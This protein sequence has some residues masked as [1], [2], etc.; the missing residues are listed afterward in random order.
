MYRKIKL[1]FLLFFSSGIL[2]GENTNIDS[3]LSIL[4][5][6]TDTSKINLMLEIADF[7]YIHGN[8]QKSKDF[9]DK[10]IGLSKKEKNIFFLAHALEFK[11]GVICNGTGDFSGALD[12]LLQ[13][14]HLINKTDYKKLLY[15]VSN[16][17]GN[18]YFA[19]KNYKK[20][21]EFY[22]TAFKTASDLKDA[23]GQNLILIGKGNVYSAQNDYKNAIEVFS[24]A[25]DGFNRKNHKSHFALAQSNI[26]DVYLKMNEPDKAL[27][28]F[29][30]IYPIFIELDNK[31]GL[32]EAYQSMGNA[33]QQKRNYQ[34]ALE[35]YYKSLDIYKQSS[36]KY[37]LKDVYKEISITY[38]KLNKNDSAF[39][40]M[41][42]YT[43]IKDSIFN[44][45]NSK[46]IAE[47]Q[48]KYESVKKEEENKSLLVQNQLSESKIKLQNRLQI[49]LLL[50][51][52][53]IFLFSVFLFRGNKQK[54]KQNTLISSQKEQV[55]EQRMQLLLK[56]KDITDSIN[57]A[58]R[59]QEAILPQ[60]KTIQLQLPK[61]FIL[62]KPKDIVAGDFYWAYKSPEAP[63][64]FYIAAADCTGHG[65]PGALVSV[66][67]SNALNRTVKEFG[68]TEPGKILDKVRDLVVETFVPS[69][70]SEAKT[71][72]EVKDGMDISLICF[73]P[74]DGTHDKLSVKWA[75]ANNPLWIVKKMENDFH[76]DEIKPNKQPIGKTDAPLPFTTHRFQIHKGDSLYLFTDGY[77]DQFGGSKDKKF[78]YQQ[79]KELILANS[80]LSMLEQQ[81]V[82]DTAIENWKG[83]S[84]QVDDIL[85]IGIRV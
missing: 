75:G 64:I 57:Y 42:L 36:A 22:E 40:Y 52:L 53:M 17:L 38:N 71:E 27:K 65:V 69:N 14:Y 39:H 45:E 84:E 85:V 50:F 74:A 56:N 66:V 23:N 49:A 21:L 82:L 73:E 34:T 28:I 5:K 19:Q 16:C 72:N 20:A 78:K 15:M 48:T 26:G 46:L 44:E 4:P 77:A 25:A 62:Y 81:K 13:S 2:L 12:Y 6:V 1:L 54:Q 9:C 29:K 3:M 60:I 31:Y 58:K 18:T 47:M 10:A 76:L 30:D 8:I 43:A 83:S 32:G 33:Y 67:C 51:L 61:S 80:H 55:E 59:L 37:D 63:S 7:Y 35:N 79:L 41:L 68:I 24:K 70:S 11:G